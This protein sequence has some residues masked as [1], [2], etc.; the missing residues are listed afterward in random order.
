MRLPWT[1]TNTNTKPKCWKDPTRTIFLKTDIKY[2]TN[3]SL[4]HHQCIIKQVTS[5]FRH[6]KCTWSSL[7]SYT[8]N[9]AKREFCWVV[10]CLV[11]LLISCKI[12]IGDNNSF[13][14]QGQERHDAGRALAPHHLSRVHS[15]HLPPHR[16]H[17]EV[18]QIKTTWPTP[19]HLGYPGVKIGESTSCLIWAT[20]RWCSWTRCSWSCFRW[21]S[22][23]LRGLSL[24]RCLFL[25]RS[26]PLRPSRSS[27]SKSSRSLSMH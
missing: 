12:L 14:P 3:A 25:Q 4:V 21:R 24:A 9:Q 2:D 11:F 26:L 23:W 18:H 20:S 19:G 22:P 7:Y 10:L 5:P 16:L 15:D 6:A 13:L 8:F 27:S 1:K 17:Q